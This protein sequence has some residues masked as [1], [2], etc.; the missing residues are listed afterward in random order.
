[1]LQRKIILELDLSINIKTS[2]WVNFS[3]KLLCYN[4]LTLLGFRGGGV[5]Q[6]PLD[7]QTEIALKIL[8]FWAEA[9]C[10][11]LKFIQKYFSNKYFFLY[12]PRFTKL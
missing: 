10:L 9:L 4:A 2:V 6:T 11:F 8:V 12:D 7:N 5:Q 3:G 1:M